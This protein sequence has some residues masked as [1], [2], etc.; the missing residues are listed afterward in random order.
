MKA[1]IGLWGDERNNM[2]EYKPLMELGESIKFNN[3]G[4]WVY[5]PENKYVQVNLNAYKDIK[6]EIHI[7][8]ED[9]PKTVPKGTPVLQP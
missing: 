7:T 2:V 1:Y 3:K 9:M 8:P 6:I 5:S 4:G